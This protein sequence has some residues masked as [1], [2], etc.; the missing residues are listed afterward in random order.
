MRREDGE[1]AAPAS[2]DEWRERVRQWNESGASCEAFAAKLG[3]KPKSLSWWRW[4][5]GRTEGASSSKT[6][7]RGPSFAPV[8]LRA[9]VAEAREESGVEVVG[10][11]GHVLRLKPDF[12]EDT[13]LRVLRLLEAV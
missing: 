13:F 11:R 1:H 12:D 9:S 4:N 5:L 8:V 10:R 7:T 2:V 3:V 6:L